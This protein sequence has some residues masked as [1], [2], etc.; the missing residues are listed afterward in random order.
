MCSFSPEN[1]NLHDN[2]VLRN[3][4]NGECPRLPS[5][6]PLQ[7]GKSMNQLSATA[8][9]ALAKRARKLHRNGELT[10]CQLLL[11]DCLLWQCRAPGSAS[12]RVSYTRL[13]SLAHLAR[14][15]I[16]AGIKRLAALGLL[17]K[18]K[19]RLIVI[20]RGRSAPR[21]GTSIY[22]FRAPAHESS[23]WTV[24][25]GQDLIIVR[26]S[27]AQEGRQERGAAT[28]LENRRRERELQ[29]QL[30]MAKPRPPGVSIEAHIRNAVAEDHMSA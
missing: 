6:R 11:L 29:I 16:A 26:A 19:V 24:N 17:A 25:Q 13:E 5:R 7:R 4:F 14:G 12:A 15:T 28:A 3:P 21:Q 2:L 30:A 1:L 20:W 22:H 18:Q 10:H 23:G 8:A 27:A 9:S